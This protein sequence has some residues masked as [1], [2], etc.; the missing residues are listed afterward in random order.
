MIAWDAKLRKLYTKYE[1]PLTGQVN[2]ILDLINQIAK[3]SFKVK[4]GVAIKFFSSNVIHTGKG[5]NPPGGTLLGIVRENQMINLQWQPNHDVNIGGGHV[6][7]VSFI[8]NAKD[9]INYC[10]ETGKTLLNSED[11]MKIIGTYITP[12]EKEPEFNI[13]GS[14]YIIADRSKGDLKQ[15]NGNKII[16]FDE[17][18]EEIQLQVLEYLT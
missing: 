18:P 14:K 16:L 8:V 13:N 4:K 2:D 12:K 1:I 6:T 15:K 17:L 5:Q 3:I 9:I 10:N 11:L 7:D